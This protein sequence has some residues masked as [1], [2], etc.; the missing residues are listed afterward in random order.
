MSR[1]TRSKTQSKA[2]PLRELVKEDAPVTKN[3]SKIAKK[4]TA[5]HVIDIQAPATRKST[6]KNS[7]VNEEH[8]TYVS[9]NSSAE[10]STRTKNGADSSVTKKRKR[11]DSSPVQER[12]VKRA[13][14]ATTMEI[15]E[16]I[17]SSHQHEDS[18]RVPKKEIKQVAASKTSN[19]TD[20]PNKDNASSAAMGNEFPLPNKYKVLS[21]VY[22]YVD[23]VFMYFKGKKNSILF[24]ELQRQV[25]QM[26]RK[27]VSLTHLRQIQ[28][29]TPQ[30]LNLEATARGSVSVTVPLDA[31]LL[32][33]T[34][35]RARLQHALLEHVT[36]LHSDWL[37]KSFTPKQ[38]RAFTELNT[39][40]ADFPLEEVPDILVG[41]TEAYTEDTA[42]K[43]KTSKKA[44]KK[45]ESEDASKLG[46]EERVEDMPDIR[47]APRSALQALHRT[48]PSDKKR[49]IDDVEVLLLG[50]SHPEIARKKQFHSAVAQFE[51]LEEKDKHVAL[52]APVPSELQG[53][54]STLIYQARL[55]EKQV[56]ADAE[57]DREGLKKRKYTLGK[58]PLLCDMLWSMYSS[59]G[60]S[61]MLYEGTVNYVLNGY[62]TSIPRDE[63]IA[64]LILLTELAPDTCQIVTLNSNK[65]L[66]M[67]R[68]SAEFVAMKNK[69]HEMYAQLDAEV[70]V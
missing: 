13:K 20:I 22:K 54:S 55:R 56:Q 6:R 29:V 31:A 66:K 39:W 1:A 65:W 44:A 18:D 14:N 28:S 48:A 19:G 67:T 68:V 59:A 58:L 2:A 33:P 8:V 24:E 50:E 49:V 23:T 38:A 46:K 45:E 25:E 62:K 69:L 21:D 47:P 9:K 57:N 16:S 30:L 63:V 42:K 11:E 40:H 70:G 27:P 5:E 32:S 10:S 17:N 26:T 7:S 3:S 53:V 51:A 34:Q 64:Q 60:K 35:R 52:S 15:D 41:Q 12:S 4:G 43:G 37:K 36:R 61:C